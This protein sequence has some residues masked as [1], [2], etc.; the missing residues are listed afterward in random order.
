MSNTPRPTRSQQ[1]EEARAKARELRE[2]RVSGEK[3]KKFL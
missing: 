2:K 3:R 1:R